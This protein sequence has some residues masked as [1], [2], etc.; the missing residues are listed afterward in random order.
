MNKTQ[1]NRLLKLA[2][3]VARS[4]NYDQNNCYKCAMAHEVGYKG[5]PTR[6]KYYGITEKE[7]DAIFG[8][9]LNKRLPTAKQKAQQI[10]RIV[11]K[12]YK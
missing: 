7:N 12:H 5:W 6:E 4:K 11:K 9:C 8:L 1:A 3:K 2:D 10:R